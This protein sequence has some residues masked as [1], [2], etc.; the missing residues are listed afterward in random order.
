MRVHAAGSV[1]GTDSERRYLI[2]SPTRLGQSAYDIADGRNMHIDFHSATPSALDEVL[3]TDE[4][5]RRAKRAPDYAAENRAMAALNREMAANPHGVLQKLAELIV[6]LCGADSAGI[7]ILEHDGENP[8]FRWRAASGPFASNL[9]GTMPR[10]ASPCGTVIARNEVLLFNRAERVFPALVGVGPPI[11]EN[12]LAPWSVGGTPTGT[13]WAIAHSPDKHFDAE[14]ARVLQSLATFAAAACQM[15]ASL[16]DANA[17]RKEL[18]QRV[19]DR[20]RE[21]TLANAVLQQEVAQRRRIEAALRESGER[22][23]RAFEIDTVGVLYF[24]LDGRITGG[25]RA[26]ARLTGYTYEQL[27][28]GTLRWDTLTPEEWISVTLHGIEQLRATASSTPF[29]KEYVKPDGTRWWGLFAGTMLDAHSGVEFVIDITEKK[30]ADAVLRESEARFHRVFSNNMIPMGLWSASGAVIDA[31]DALLDMLG[32]TRKDLEAGRLL[33]NEIT[34]SEYR[35][36]DAQALSELEQQGFC[37]PYEKHFRHKDGHPIPILVGGGRLDQDGVT[38]VLFAIDMTEQKRA[39][40]ARRQ[41][42]EQQAFLLSVSDALRRATDVEAIHDAAARGLATYLEA[43]RAFYC[44][45]NEQRHAVKVGPDYRRDGI[46]AADDGCV[47][48]GFRWTMDELCAGRPVVVNDTQG[49]PETD[50]AGYAALGMRACIAMPL[51]KNGRLAATCVILDNVPRT[52]SAAQVASAREVTERTWLAV[53]RARAEEALREADR[54]KD[55]FMATLAHELRNPLAPISNAMQL[56]RQSVGRRRTDR[57]VEMVERQVRQMVKLVDDLLEISRITR[58]KIDL[59]KQPLLLDDVVRSALE[60]SR[61]LIDRAQLNLTVQLPDQAVLLDGDSVRLTQV[62]SNLLNNAANYTDA[63]GCVC[64][65]AWR[66]GGTAVIAVRDNGIG[67]PASQL[68]H[69][70]EMFTQVHRDTGRRHG[71][72]GVGLAMVRNLVLMHGGSV[73]AHSA[74]PGQGSEFIVRLPAL[75]AD[76][77]DLAPPSTEGD[78][79]SL[80]GQRFL[81]VDDNHDAADSLA[82]LLQAEG[83]E[84]RIAYDGPAALATLDSMRPDVVL[85]GLGMPGMDGCEVARRIRADQRFRGVRLV[86]LTG[87]GQESDRLRTRDSGFDHHLTK[88]VDYAM[89]RAWLSDA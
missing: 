52:W 58:G 87:W 49:L 31:N 32:Y 88:P 76:A 35:G 86:A 50:R 89:L 6:D 23:R 44:E 51:L 22:F 45:W 75:A 61:P 68:P 26:L 30:H 4:L 53:E 1:A 33:W 77:T 3:I 78:R 37:T 2:F 80:S 13:V 20:T 56:L 5:G 19:E 54:R 12:L 57:L 10:E 67:I 73:E 79:A 42:E 16:D 36:R 74:G 25:N 59:V 65:A 62:L 84:V 69:V 46:A 64:V 55:E 34:P 27:N 29:E 40:R 41:S 85:M 38:G 17:G 48:A 66:D 14:D 70:F 11:C 18:E 21:L 8:V 28:S 39:E 7:S 82:M 24:D 72:L 43:A 15:V 81:V 83:A 9:G 60:I 71:G 63:G 47:I